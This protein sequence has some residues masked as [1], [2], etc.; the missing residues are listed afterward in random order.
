MSPTLFNIW[1]PLSIHAYGICIAIG[2]AV[3]IF[4]V[5]RDAQL[6]RILSSDDLTHSFQI[7]LLA[8]YFGGRLVC[9][10]SHQEAIDDYLFLFRFWEPGFSILGSI[11]GIIT[12][13]STYLYIKKISILLYADRISLYAP[14]VQSFGRIGCFFAGCCFGKPS[15]A[16]WAV[17]YDNVDHMAPLH[18]SL[19]PAQM[20]SSLMLMSLFLFLYFIAQR[21]T[22]KPGL[23]FCTYLF[24][25]SV[26]RFVIDFVRW[27]REFIRNSPSLSSLSVHQLIALALCLFTLILIVYIQK[28]TQR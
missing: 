18:Q 26:E 16:W 4:L 9:M 19:H 13:L 15:S 2:A 10:F 12:A 28:R 7:I 23:L 3:A 21:H 22:K 14:L 8:G 20:Y 25:A 17:T 6:K 27:D 24:F 5:M 1:G 11:I